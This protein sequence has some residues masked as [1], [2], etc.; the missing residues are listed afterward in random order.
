[1]GITGI[2]IL[3]HALCYYTVFGIHRKVFSA[4]PRINTSRPQGRKI[5]HVSGP[6]ALI[7][8]CLS[9]QTFYS[10]RYMCIGYVIYCTSSSFSTVTYPAGALR[11]VGI[12][13][14]MVAQVCSTVAGF[15]T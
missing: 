4:R 5:K 8:H 3:R 6:A 12:L 9:F 7:S 13:F 1:M 11:I 15:V 10:S 14:T 2:C